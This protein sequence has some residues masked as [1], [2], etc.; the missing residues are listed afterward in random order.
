M[1]TKDYLY[2]SEVFGPTVQG[3]GPYLGRR[4][5][6]LR[7]LGCNLTCS[8]CDTKYTWDFQNYPRPLLEDSKKS[9][10]EVR[11]MV[12]GAGLDEATIL[13]ISGGEPLLQW[14]GLEAFLDYFVADYE[15]HIETNGTQAPLN[16]P[17]VHYNVSPKLINANTHLEKYDHRLLRAFLLEDAIFKF[18]CQRPE[19][20]DEVKQTFPYL[21]PD[22]VYIMP[23]G[24]SAQAVQEH[25]KAVA[26]YAIQ[27]HYNLTTRLHTMVWGDERGR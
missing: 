9:L 8:W 24:T 16:V 26:E 19:D 23:E 20:V 25:L 14:Q 7:L 6:F 10:D 22:R 2:V 18:V 15:V 4:A 3:E 5:V 11:E 1:P 27:N 13:V 12:F 17:D 21:P